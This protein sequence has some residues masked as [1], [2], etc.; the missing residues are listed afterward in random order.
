MGNS[1]CIED[2]HKDMSQKCSLFPKVA[3]VMKTTRPDDLGW[4]SGETANLDHDLVVKAMVRGS[5]IENTR[6]IITGFD[7]LGRPSGALRL[8]PLTV[9]VHGQVPRNAK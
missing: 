5:A 9:S 6:M 7:D 3:V 2:L 4:W 1:L 8:S